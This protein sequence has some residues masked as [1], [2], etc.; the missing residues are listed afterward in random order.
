[1]NGDR[2][3]RDVAPNRPF[4]GGSYP[5]N[6]Q[7]ADGVASHIVAAELHGLG[8]P[9]VRQFPV[10]MAGVSLQEAREAA[11]NW[12][13]PDNL[14]VVIVGRGAEVDRQDRRPI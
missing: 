8:L 2:A 12:L 3:L 6:L 10:R 14:W 1:L 9:Y 7:T 4:P 13:N 5:F 11:A